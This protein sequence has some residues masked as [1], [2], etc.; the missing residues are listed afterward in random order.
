MTFV[1]AQVVAASLGPADAIGVVRDFRERTSRIERRAIRT[2]PNTAFGEFRIGVFRVAREGYP[3]RS[4]HPDCAT[5][6]HVVPDHSTRE[7]GV[8]ELESGGLGSM[9]DVVLYPQI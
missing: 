1:R 7:P 6:Y 9:E 8:L 4:A 5:M 2:G 3:A